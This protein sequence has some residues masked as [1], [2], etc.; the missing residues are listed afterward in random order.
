[1]IILISPSDVMT[2]ESMFTKTVKKVSQLGLAIVAIS[3]SPALA[4]PISPQ[5]LLTI[6]S[7]HSIVSDGGAVINHYAPDGSVK[8]TTIKTGKTQNRKW[9]VTNKS[10]I[11]VVGKKKSC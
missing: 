10:N 9:Y 8:S 6:Y 1:M 4:A 7:G 3:A 5:E 11:C 2:E